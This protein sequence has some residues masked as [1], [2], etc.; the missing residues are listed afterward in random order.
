MSRIG[1]QPV[2]I[3]SGVEVKVDGKTVS[4]K[5]T[6][7]N[8]ERTFPEEVTFEIKDGQVRV[9]RQW[10]SLADAAQEAED[11]ERLAEYAQRREACEATAEGHAELAR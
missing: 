6:K 8:L 9:G 5:G 2:A 10:L 11:N 1:K 4:V 3:P 7:G